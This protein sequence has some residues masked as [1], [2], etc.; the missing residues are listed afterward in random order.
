MISET[1]VLT[2]PLPISH[3]SEESINNGKVEDNSSLSMSDHYEQWLGFHLDSPM[4]R[5]IKAL[6]GFLDFNVWLNK[7]MHMFLGCSDPKKRI[8]LIKLGKGSLTSH[9]GQ[10]LFRHLRSY[11]IHDMVVTYVFYFSQLDNEKVKATNEHNFSGFL[12]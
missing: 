6:Q 11:F 2:V 7:E 5:F 4:Q 3:L 8:K 12:Q 10:G 9:P 1:K